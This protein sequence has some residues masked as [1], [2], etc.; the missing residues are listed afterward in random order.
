MSAM[1]FVAMMSTPVCH[2]LTGIEK[3]LAGRL[4][5]GLILADEQPFDQRPEMDN[6]RSAARRCRHVHNALVAV[7]SDRLLGG[8]NSGNWGIPHICRGNYLTIDAQPVGVCPKWN[9]VESG[10][11]FA[12]GEIQYK[13]N[14]GLSSVKFSTRPDSGFPPM[15]GIWTAVQHASA[16]QADQRESA[17]PY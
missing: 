11:G 3:H 5:R 17:R 8:A 2:P 6:G 16:L 4:P 1:R 14:Q 10:S 7:Q 13:A 9:S 12:P 15:I